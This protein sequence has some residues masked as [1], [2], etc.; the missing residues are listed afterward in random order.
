[1]KLSPCD[2]AISQG[3]KESY[4]LSVRVQKIFKIETA[5]AVASR[6]RRREGENRRMTGGDGIGRKMRR[7]RGK[8]MRR[9][10]KITRIKR[11]KI[12]E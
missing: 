9:R 3:R 8:R 5:K 7:R 11:R 6:K 2:G 4:S 10:R 1:V 12:M